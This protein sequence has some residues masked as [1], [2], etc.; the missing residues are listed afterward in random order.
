M[1]LQRWQT[2]VL[3]V[4]RRKDLPKPETDQEFYE[5]EDGNLV[6]VA[7]SKDEEIELA[8]EQLAEIRAFAEE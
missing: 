1:E 6:P 5:D 8:Y 3:V 7:L 4:G 2:P